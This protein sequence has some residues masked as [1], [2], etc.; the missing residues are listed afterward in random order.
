[1]T[2]GPTA[3]VA[4]VLGRSSGER[5]GAGALRAVSRYASTS[6]SSGTRT[7]CP[8]FA[9]SPCTVL[10]RSGRSS[11]DGLVDSS[12]S[13]NATLRSSVRAA[14]G[15]PP[16]TRPQCTG[17]PASGA[18]AHRVGGHLEVAIQL[19]GD[20]GWWRGLGQCGT[21]EDEP[22][23]AGGGIDGKGG[24]AH[25]EARMAALVV[26]G[27]RAAPVLREEERQAT[28]GGGKIGLGIERPE[29]RVGGDAGVEPADEVL[30]EGHPTG[31]LVQAD[32]RQVGHRRS[33]A[34]A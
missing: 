4:P 23:V 8:A 6:A 19:G 32:G 21:H 9:A 22:A 1:M 15:P 14:A 3:T 18:V 11:A 33:L 17:R 10:P 16:T 24:V 2:T 13:A 28:L 26:V 27:A 5:S 7:R 31:S 25:P 20:V 30:E 12:V 29:D 34:S